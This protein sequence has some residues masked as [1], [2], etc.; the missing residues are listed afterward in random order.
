MKCQICPRIS[1][2]FQS[3]TLKF[4]SYP[5]KSHYI[6]TPRKSPRNSRQ[7]HH[8]GR[9]NPTEPPRE[10]IRVAPCRQTVRSTGNDRWAQLQQL[11]EARH[12]LREFHGTSRAFDWDLVEFHGILIGIL[13]GIWWEFNLI[14]W[15]LMGISWNLHEFNGILMGIQRI[16]RQQY[17]IPT[18]QSYKSI[19][20]IVTF[21]L[22]MAK[23]KLVTF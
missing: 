5:I 7:I 15:D 18:F 16:Q 17:W 1:M 23:W 20:E 2:K 13:I 21:D 12:Y 10:P 6:I 8:F 19:S 11:L 4:H 22:S 3:I 14:S 9:H